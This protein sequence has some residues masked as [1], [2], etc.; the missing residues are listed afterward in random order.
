[1]HHVP[2]PVA[3][4]VVLQLNAER[5]VVPEAADAAVNL[6]GLEDEAAALAERD[7]GLHC[8]FFTHGFE[9]IGAVR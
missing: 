4:D 2:P 6:A 9:F 5:A 3:L 8:V 1:L 7:E